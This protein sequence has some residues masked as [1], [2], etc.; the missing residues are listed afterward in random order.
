MTDNDFM[1]LVADEL[2]A[3][4]TAEQVPLY[5][6]GILEI[7]KNI[8]AGKY[9]KEKAFIKKQSQNILIAKIVK[10]LECLKI[11]I[12][13][14]K[15]LVNVFFLIGVITLLG[16]RKMTKKIKVIL[17][18]FKQTSYEDYTH[19]FKTVEIEV[20]Y[21]KGEEGHVCGEEYQEPNEIKE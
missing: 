20:H 12:T 17:T 19:F 3:Y 13:S 18:C 1:E 6:K 7:A 11:V 9:E 8:N 2:H 15:K 5:K 10:S 4:I 21:N 14:K 16:G